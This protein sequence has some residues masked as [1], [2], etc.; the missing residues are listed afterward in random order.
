MENLRDFLWNPLNMSKFEL[1]NILFFKLVR[2]LPEIDGSHKGP[3]KN[4][5]ILLG[6]RGGHQKITKD[7]RGG[8]G[9]S[10]KRSH[11]ITRGG[12]MG[13]HQCIIKEPKKTLSYHNEILKC[14][15]FM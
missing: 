14:C 12:V 8:G 10:L 3:F 4:Y 9:G 2:I 15:G 1:K 13:D 5:V 7:H 11:R 6:G